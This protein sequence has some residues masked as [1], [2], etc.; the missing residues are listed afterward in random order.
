MRAMT[1]TTGPYPERPGHR[2]AARHG[3]RS[4]VALALTLMVLSGCGAGGDDRSDDLSTPVCDGKLKGDA[5]S[6][7][8]GS[9]GLEKEET[10][11]FAPAKWQASGSCYLYGKKTFLA[12][13][14]L[15]YS[16]GTTSLARIRT[17]APTTVQT[18]KVGSATG[19]VEDKRTRVVVPCAIP[20][21]YT[22]DEALLE[23]EVKYPFD[24][25]DKAHREAFVSATTIAARY[26]ADDVFKCPAIDSGSGE[27]TGTKSPSP[28]GS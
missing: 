26:L 3:L 19:Y 11:Q 14:Y 2:S 27:E 5:F 12:I 1:T 18:F 25:I 17:A 8:V 24:T 4:L 21:S 28:S 23:V 6:E 22:S 10:K 16:K 7:L 13:D 15:W 20:G 9:G